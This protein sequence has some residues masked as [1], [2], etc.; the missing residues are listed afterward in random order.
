MSE[1]SPLDCAV[2]WERGP[3]EWWSIQCLHK[4]CAVID[5]TVG[6]SNSSQDLGVV[7]WTVLAVP[8]VRIVSFTRED[9]AEYQGVGSGQLVERS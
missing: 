2:V 8:T 4:L 1:A 3:N 7:P 9:S 6:L 5:G